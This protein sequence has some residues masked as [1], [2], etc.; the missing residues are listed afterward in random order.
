MQEVGRMERAEPAMGAWK[1]KSG[2]ERETGDVRYKDG[3]RDSSEDWNYIPRPFE[4]HLSSS[5]SSEPQ[6]KF[7]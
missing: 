1:T 2:D 6:T 4:V 3:K 7:T 5:S